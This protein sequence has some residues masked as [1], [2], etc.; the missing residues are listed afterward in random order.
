M[1]KL[2]EE[3]V[4]CQVCKEHERGAD[5]AVGQQ[6][7]LSAAQYLLKE[8]RATMITVCPAIG[9]FL[10]SAHDCHDRCVTEMA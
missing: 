3:M 1:A 9:L 5:R 4:S 8:Y 2:H 6:T 10:I 7:Q